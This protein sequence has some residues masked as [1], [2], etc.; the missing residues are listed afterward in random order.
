[1]S[2]EYYSTGPD[3]VR[4]VQRL[5]ARIASRYDLIND[6]QSFGL[7]RV[8]KRQLVKF[9]QPKAGQQALD[10][11]C[12]T[13]DLSVY[14]A[15]A[16][17][18]VIGCDFSDAMLRVAAARRRINLVQ[19]DALHLPFDDAKFDLVTIG[20]GLRNLADFKGGL[21][22]LLRVLKPGGRLLILDFGKPSNRFWRGLYFAYLRIIVP[23]FGLI[24][25]G[26]AG[27]YR[28]I[29]ESLREYPAQSGIAQILENLNCSRVDIHNLLGGMMSIHLAE[30]RG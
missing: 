3:R 19:G 9:A 22:E 25:C 12:G 6:L 20:Y 24:F 13:G 14:L 23:V 17:L 18:K 4:N 5:F 29:L 28:Y 10:V 30:R 8:W 2:A 27:A 1:M 21:A 7:H 26:E 11:C 15:D 16:G